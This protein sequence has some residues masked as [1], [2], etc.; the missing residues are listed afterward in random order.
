M[1]AG[2]AP[3]LYAE[4]LFAGPPLGSGRGSVPAATVAEAR[5]VDPAR[6][7]LS[8][9]P[10]N[11]VRAFSADCLQ[12]LRAV[13]P[14]SG[15]P[16]RPVL[17]HRPRSLTCVRVNRCGNLEGARKLSGRIPLRVALPTDLDLLRRVRVGACLSG[18]ERW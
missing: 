10:R 8:L 2:D 12:Y 15:L 11:V 17:K 16:I 18:P 4:R 14:A 6:G 5:A 1:G 7:T 3:W 13:A 9:W